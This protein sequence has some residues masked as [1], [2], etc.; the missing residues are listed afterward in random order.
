MAFHGQRQILRP[1]AD[2]VILHQNAVHPAA[3]QRDGDAKRPGIQ[4]IFDNF[5][6]RG[7]RAFHNLTRR[8][9]VRGGF[10]Q[11]ANGRA[12]GHGWGSGH[13]SL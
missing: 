11:Q 1:H 6:E 9:A 12:R 4:R 7:S 8:D 2:A 10:R 13:A 3:F 5:L